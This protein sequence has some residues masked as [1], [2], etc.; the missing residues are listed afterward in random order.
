MIGRAVRDQSHVALPP[1]ERKVQVV[2]GPKPADKTVG[3]DAAPYQMSRDKK[4][5]MQALLTRRGVTG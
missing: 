4:A 3:A 5:E 1:N 2:P